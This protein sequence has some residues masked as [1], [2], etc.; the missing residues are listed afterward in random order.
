MIFLKLIS[1]LVLTKY[2]EIKILFKPWSKLSVCEWQSQIIY[3]YHLGF[4]K[5]SKKK[6]KIQILIFSSMS[7][8]RSF[9]PC[10]AWEC[11]SLAASK[12]VSL[13][14]GAVKST[15]FKPEILLN[16]IVKY[17]TKYGL[18]SSKYPSKYR[19][20]G[21][22]ANTCCCLRFCPVVACTAIQPGKV[23][24]MRHIWR[25][26]DQIIAFHAMLCSR[27]VPHIWSGSIEMVMVS[28]ECG[29]FSRKAW[30]IW[31]DDS[32]PFFYDT[33]GS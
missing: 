7:W 6:S 25:D 15:C 31:R 29:Q 28:Y 33:V 14:S 3:L 23:L 13:D 30:H 24:N 10:L 21:L 11:K 2:S 19:A 16:K 5:M 20:N 12:L 8:S 9:L 26:T 27:W 4:D 18:L 32:S 22:W 1:N 17:I